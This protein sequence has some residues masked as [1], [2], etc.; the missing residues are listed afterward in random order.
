MLQATGAV[1][2]RTGDVTQNSRNVISVGTQGDRL[3]ANSV[4]TDWSIMHQAAKLIVAAVWKPVLATNLT[5]LMGTTLWTN[6]HNGMAI[7]CSTGDLLGCAS[8]N[9]GS[10]VCLETGNSLT[11]N[12]AIVTSVLLDW[13][14]AT[15]ALRAPFAKNGGSP[16]G[17][18]VQTSAPSASSTSRRLMLFGQPSA[19]AGTTAGNCLTAGS[20]I[21]EVIIVTGANA[22]EPNRAALH[23]YL[24]NKWAVY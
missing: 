15:V 18:N 11:P 8:K 2:P 4:A 21:G 13:S 14:N 3:Y 17:N 12:A 20:W 1:Q 22:T 19:D 9:G 5:G 7:Y 6:S 24:N 23:T 10:L 16:T